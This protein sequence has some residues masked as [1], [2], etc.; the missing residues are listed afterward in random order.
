MLIL[1]VSR[2]W[3]TFINMCHAF[4]LLVAVVAASLSA[5]SLQAA[6]VLET[7]FIAA[8][9]YSD[10]PLQFQNGWLGQNVDG[11]PVVKASGA[12]VVKSNNPYLRNL[13]GKGAHGSTAGSD[14]DGV[15]PGFAIGDVFK[16]EIEVAYDLEDASNV[17]LNA[18]GVRENFSSAGFNAGPTMGLSV[19]FSQYDPAKGGSLRVFSNL[20]RSSSS[21]SDVPFGL[22]IDGHDIG[23][24][25]SGANGP[26]DLSSDLLV[27]TLVLEKTSETQWTATELTVR[28]KDTGAVLGRASV[29]KPKALETTEFTGG[30]AY[31]AS[32]WTG[33][34]ATT[35]VGRVRFEFV[36]LPPEPG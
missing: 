7:G 8:E 33:S 13:Y 28:N 11:Q 34:N 29:D 25:P 35:K 6:E 20:A 10:G 31:F 36:P 22:M 12:G 26:V 19:G 23:L 21:A 24:D 17:I 14:T 16:I 30:D 3:N 32:R 9:G 27:L 5:A 18:T 15:G 2:G 1:T 4:K